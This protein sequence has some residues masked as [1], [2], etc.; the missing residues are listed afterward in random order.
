MLAALLPRRVFALHLAAS[1]SLPRLCLAAPSLDFA[2][3]SPL[4][5]DLLAAAL[6]PRSNKVPC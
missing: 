1:L 5:P 2:V 3:H 6:L 4:S